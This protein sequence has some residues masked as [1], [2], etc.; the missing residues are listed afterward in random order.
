MKGQRARRERMQAWLFLLPNL[1]G[2]G[3]FT[4]GPVVFS[5]W[6]AF[7][8]TSLVKHNAFSE[9]PV[10]FVGF[11]NFA[12]ILWG[13]ESRLFWES[14]GNTAY[15]M[16]GIPIGIVGSLL[17]ALMLNRPVGPA[18]ARG[19]WTLA[20]IA[21]AAGMISAGA[22]L[23]VTWPVEGGRGEQA[24]QVEEEDANGVKG[25]D[26]ALASELARRRALAIAAL[27]V[28]SGGASAASLR[29]AVAKVESQV[30]SASSIPS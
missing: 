11:R 10:K 26:E 2:F 29:S 15:L 28:I 9:T 8:D 4:A 20:G 30:A 7:T 1:L 25:Q 27:L 14:M 3:L 6:L 5:L 21:L 17:V 22:A 13:D 19:K 24:R 18:R 16:L 23:M 12:R